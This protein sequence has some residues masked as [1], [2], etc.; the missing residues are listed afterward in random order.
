MEEYGIENYIS[1]FNLANTLLGRLK[2]HCILMHAHRMR[3]ERDIAYH[4]AEAVREEIMAIAGEIKNETAKKRFK[5]LVQQRVQSL[6]QTS[7]FELA[8]NADPFEDAED[9]EDD[10]SFIR[11]AMPEETTYAYDDYAAEG[12]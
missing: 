12:V 2:Q 5:K 10:D 9:D 4:K 6:Y 1:V 7:F 8:V 11:E 3:H